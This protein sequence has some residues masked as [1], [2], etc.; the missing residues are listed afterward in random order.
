[1]NNS[2]SYQ[3]L[4]DGYKGGAQ[5]IKKLGISGLFIQ[6]GIIGFVN[7]WKHL[8]IA[9]YEI[10]APILFSLSIYYLIKDFFNFRKIDRVYTQMILE[11]VELEKQNTG[12]GRFFHNI[13]QSFNFSQTLMQ[14]SLVNALA[15]GCLVYLISQ[16]ISDVTPGIVISRWILGLVV[17]VPSVL[18]CKFYYD[19][20]K[21][22]DETR[23]QVFAK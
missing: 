2:Q 1:M 12:L 6:I 18:A 7:G 15:L 22:L 5:A 17:W 21:L 14:R 8:E 13:L 19:S 23:E 9:N 10:A 16:F 20:L 11:G 3:S 4:V